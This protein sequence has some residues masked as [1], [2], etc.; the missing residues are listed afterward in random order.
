MADE[1]KPGVDLQQLATFDLKSTLAPTVLGGIILTATNQLA[2][3]LGVSPIIFAF[4]TSALFSAI[5]LASNQGP[6][7]RFFMWPIL[8]FVVFNATTGTNSLTNT[9]VSRAV[10]EGAASVSQLVEP[11]S[12]YAQPEPTPKPDEWGKP[13]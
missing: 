7:M 8:T 6:V 12:A 9:D 4:G 3:E 1:A 2:P 13:W 5:V 10:R 11:T